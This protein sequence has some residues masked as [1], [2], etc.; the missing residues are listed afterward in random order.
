MLQLSSKLIPNEENITS[1]VIDGEAVLVNLSTGAYYSLLG[2]AC[3]AWVLFEQATTVGETAAT[4]TARYGVALKQV[5]EDLGR[6]AEV[7][8]AE[9]I[10]SASEQPEKMANA[11]ELPPPTME[12]KAPELEVYRDMEELLALD[13]PMPGLRDVPWVSGEGKRSKSGPA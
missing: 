6:F 9:G 12:Y 7:L 2:A 11:A 5:E 10:A 4:L 13:P 1:S 3:D 8:V